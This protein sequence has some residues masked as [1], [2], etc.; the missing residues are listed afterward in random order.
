[1][2]RHEYY[3]ISP[4]YFYYFLSE[5]TENLTWKKVGEVT[6]TASLAL[7][8]AFSEL[9]VTVG[10][11]IFYIPSVLLDDT[12]KSYYYGKVASNGHYL[13]LSNNTVVVSKTSIR[14]VAYKIE[15]TSSVAIGG[16]T[17][18]TSSTTMTVY[19]R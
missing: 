5:L 15:N 14:M 17:N 7:P 16:Y 10:T 1:M 9:L 6:G 19:Y 13:T 11:T 12:D 2:E 8:S 18:I 3:H 4:I